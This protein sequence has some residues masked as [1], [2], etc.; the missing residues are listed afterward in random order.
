MEHNPWLIKQQGMSEVQKYNN[1]IKQILGFLVV[2]VGFKQP[3]QI[4]PHE[5]VTKF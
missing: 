5:H 2:S 4:T 1:D 3:N